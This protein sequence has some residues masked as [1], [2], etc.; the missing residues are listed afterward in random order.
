MPLNLDLAN[1]SVELRV[2]YLILVSTLDSA[3][4]HQ[5]RRSWRNILISLC[6]RQHW[7]HCGSSSL[8]SATW[9]P[10]LVL[11]Y[12][13]CRPKWDFNLSDGLHILPAD[14][15]RVLSK[16]IKYMKSSD[17]LKWH[18]GQQKKKRDIKL[19]T[20]L[21]AVTVSI[22]VYLDCFFFGGGDNSFHSSGSSVFT[23][24]NQ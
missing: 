17:K 11:I 6:L 3:G 8:Q 2:R 16:M 13:F 21:I 23:S 20:S 4:D 5:S 7:R 9:G 18:F 19:G 1:F 10:T 24:S 15:P 12:F 22:M 14:S